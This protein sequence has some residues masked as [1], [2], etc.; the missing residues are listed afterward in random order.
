[1][2]IR[3]YHHT[4][5]CK[6]FVPNANLIFALGFQQH[7]PY[8]W[9]TIQHL[10]KNLKVPERGIVKIYTTSILVTGM[11]PFSLYAPSGYYCL[12]M[13]SPLS[14][15]RLYHPSLILIPCLQAIERIDPCC[16]THLKR[17]SC[18]FPDDVNRQ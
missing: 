15:K 9:P 1:M 3:T 6:L 2:C 7:V 16:P 12:F 8:P 14:R 13:V 17:S 10:L 18:G 5:P 11:N 4:I